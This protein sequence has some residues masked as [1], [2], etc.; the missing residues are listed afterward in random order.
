MLRIHDDDTF[1]SNKLGHVNFVRYG[2]FKFGENLLSKCGRK[3]KFENTGSQLS[4]VR[5]N[6]FPH[7][8]EVHIVFQNLSGLNVPNLAKVQ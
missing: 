2:C 3:T 8:S 6:I 4:R 7:Q 1:F 5:S